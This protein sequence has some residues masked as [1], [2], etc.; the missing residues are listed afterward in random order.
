MYIA[1]PP[2]LTYFFPSSRNAPSIR[3]SQLYLLGPSHELLLQRRL[4]GFKVFYV[5]HTSRQ[6]GR[7][8][9][10]KQGR[11]CT[12]DVTPSRVYATIVVVENQLMLRILSVCL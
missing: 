1:V 3:H 12:Y 11:Q 8:A 5:Y 10:N 9:K 7:K 6:N 4:L 2:N